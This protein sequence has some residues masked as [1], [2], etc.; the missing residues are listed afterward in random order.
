MSSFDF[1][2]SE[3]LVEE[4]VIDV[5]YSSMQPLSTCGFYKGTSMAWACTGVNTFE[6]VDL[7][8]T[9]TCVNNIQNVSAPH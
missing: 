8:V 1:S 4:D 9:G 7:D 5:V 6:I 3:K 2:L